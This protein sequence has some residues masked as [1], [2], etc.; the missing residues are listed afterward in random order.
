[1]TSF[2]DN[3]ILCLLTCAKAATC[4]VAEYP[5]TVN[6]SRVPNLAEAALVDQL[7][8]SLQGGIAIGDV[9]L[10]QLQHVQDGFV[11][12]STETAQNIEPHNGK[13]SVTVN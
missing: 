13:T 12:L 8:H 10:H 4:G 9:W 3:G 1:M 6:K 7:P 2:D 5:A 11:H